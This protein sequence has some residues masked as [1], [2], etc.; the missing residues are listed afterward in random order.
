MTAHDYTLSYCPEERYTQPITIS[1]AS[2]QYAL[3]STNGFIS[4]WYTPPPQTIDPHVAYILERQ[5]IAQEAMITRDIEE[6]EERRRME[7][8]R[9][10]RSCGLDTPPRDPLKPGRVIEP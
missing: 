9:K 5:R 7:R 6:A 8:V 3:T 1:N 2:G 4:Y 10:L